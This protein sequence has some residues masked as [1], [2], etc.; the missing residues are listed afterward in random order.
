MITRD[1]IRDAA[2]TLAHHWT[3]SEHRDRLGV[4][5]LY[6]AYPVELQR[7]LG[8]LVMRNLELRGFYRQAAAFE[9][10][11]FDLAGLEADTVPTTLEDMAR[12]IAA[13]RAV[14]EQ[15]FERED[16]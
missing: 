2:S 13:E 9:R 5:R 7:P 10:M 6:L 4:E 16:V 11:L 8:A 1:N 3:S 15:S 12:D 14:A